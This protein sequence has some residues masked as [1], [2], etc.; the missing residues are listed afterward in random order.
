MAISAP[1]VTA[2]IHPRR[3]SPVDRP[4]TASSSSRRAPICGPM[5]VPIAAR[6]RSTWPSP[7]DR[8]ASLDVA[9]AT[10]GPNWMK[11][12]DASISANARCI[13]VASFVMACNAGGTSTPMRR[14]LSVASVTVR[15]S[16]A[17]SASVSREVPPTRSTAS[18]ISVASWITFRPENE[19]AIRPSERATL[20]A[21]SSKPRS[22]TSASFTARLKSVKSAL[23]CPVMAM[24]VRTPASSVRHSAQTRD[25][26]GQ[27]PEYFRQ[28]ESVL[29]RV[30]HLLGRGRAES[31]PSKSRLSPFIAPGRGKKA[32]SAKEQAFTSLARTTNRP[33][34]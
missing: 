19:S 18:T 34:G 31:S 28:R 12:R 11:G 22:S 6:I 2:P 29:R 3:V 30:A 24:G 15:A 21:S 7:A 16:R 5:L 14:I 33:G 8:P 13:D 20:L 1:P 4:P 32:R 9:P 27:F 25:H 26:G 17:N 10:P 23:K